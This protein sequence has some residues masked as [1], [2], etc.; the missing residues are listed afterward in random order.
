MH[1]KTFF[2]LAVFITAILSQNIN[3]SA[4]QMHHKEDKNV[5]LARVG[6]VSTSIRTF[7]HSWKS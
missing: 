4:A 5:L 6:G 3:L 2:S 7:P 1:F